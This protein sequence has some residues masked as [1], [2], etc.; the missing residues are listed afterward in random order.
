MKDGKTYTHT[1]SLADVHT[2]KDSNIV[3]QNTIMDYMVDG[4]NIIASGSLVFNADGE[5]KLIN[6]DAVAAEK[7]VGDVVV[8]LKCCL[9]GDLKFLAVMLGKENYE[10]WWCC[11]CKMFKDD[12]QGSK[13]ALTN[14]D[15]WTIETLEDQALLNG[16]RFE[17]EEDGGRLRMGVKT[18]PFLKGNIQ[19][20]FPALH[21]MMGIVNDLMCYFFDKIDA[22]IEPVPRE[23][24]QL[25]DSIP[26][27]KL[28]LLTQQQDF[29][30]WVDAQNGGVELAEVTGAL[31]MLKREMRQLNVESDE[32]K[33]QAGIKKAA[34]DHRN[35]LLKVKKQFEDEIAKLKQEIKDAPKEI[36]KLRKA[37]KVLASSLYSK[38]ELIFK[39]FG[40][41]RGSYHGGNF[42]G[43][44]IIKLMLHS[45]KI[46]DQVTT[47]FED[48]GHL[49]RKQ[50]RRPYATM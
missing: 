3:L 16:W 8:D 37:R 21:A 47:L 40:V 9:T 22:E 43:V 34:E 26:A 49:R 17:S 50:C 4:M 11:F 5:V 35:D 32:Y 20:V 24:M 36:A 45:K 25:R 2:K 33:E 13:P 10:G 29:A 28:L 44:N 30:V 7:E 15:C 42:N 48:E 39:E 41:E 18:L 27:N 31:K 14:D 12:W 23:E 6:T 38:C 19:V 1:Y 46:M